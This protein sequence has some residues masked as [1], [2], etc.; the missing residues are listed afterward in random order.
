MNTTNQKHTDL[1]LS[2]YFDKTVGIVIVAILIIAVVI[3]IMFAK[4]RRE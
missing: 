1:I 3:L 4:S 2:F